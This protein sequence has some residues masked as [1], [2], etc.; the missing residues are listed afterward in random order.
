MTPKSGEEIDIR[1][2][3]GDEKSPP[4]STNTNT[5]TKP[6]PIVAITNEKAATTHGETLPGWTIMRPLKMRGLKKGSRSN[7]E[8]ATGNSQSQ[9]AARNGSSVSSADKKDDLRATS[10]NGSGDGV[11]EVD[12]LSEV[13][14]DDELLG[15]DGQQHNAARG[16]AGTGMDGTAEEGG[17]VVYKVY[18]RRWFGLVQL[19]LLN[20]IVSW[21]VSNLHLLP[22]HDLTLIS[23]SLF[24]RIRIQWLNTTIPRNRRLIGLVQASYLHLWLR[25]RLCY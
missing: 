18:K 3:E 24:P 13:R 25:L 11:G 21:D 16:G 22:I 5:N 1:A 4:V 17:S 10:T 9:G 12:V 14:S 6:H 23:G 2:A 15:D 20:I 7:A 19:V 8:S